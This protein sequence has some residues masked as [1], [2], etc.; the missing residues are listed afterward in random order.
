MHHPQISTQSPLVETRAFRAALAS[1]ETWTHEGGIHLL[2]GPSGSGRST[3]LEVHSRP[4]RDERADGI[5]LHRTA[6]LDTPLSLVR[7][8]LGSLGL[9]WHGTTRAGQDVLEHLG[10]GRGLRLLVVDDARLLSRPALE[11]LRQL[12]D[13]TGVALVLAGDGGLLRRLE[14]RAPALRAVVRS[15]HVVAPLELPDV[16]ALMGSPAGGH[17]L[18]SWRQEATAKALLAAGNGNMRQVLHLLDGVQRLAWE[19]GIPVSPGLVGRVAEGR[20]RVA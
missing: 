1:L 13:R 3:I 4:E 16:L 12:H 20:E 11:L 2:V 5:L 19:R 8:F 9:A 18:V 10:V 6:V 7:S 17:G 14:L 15:L